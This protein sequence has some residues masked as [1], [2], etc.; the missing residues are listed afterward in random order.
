MV[1]RLSIK[2]ESKS[3]NFLQELLNWK[4]KPAI[5][6]SFDLLFLHTIKCKVPFFR[7]LPPQLL[8]KCKSLKGL[9]VSF[10]RP[11][12]EEVVPIDTAADEN[13]DIGG[14]LQPRNPS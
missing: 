2:F 10:M 13:K 8:M 9:A 1:T 4:E 12:G 6:H 7:G 3:R 5:P 11:Q 14:K